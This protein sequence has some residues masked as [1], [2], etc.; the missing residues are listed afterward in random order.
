METKALMWAWMAFDRDK[1]L[2]LFE[3]A[4]AAIDEMRTR[5]A[6]DR[7]D[8]DVVEEARRLGIFL[9]VVDV[10]VRVVSALTAPA[11]STAQP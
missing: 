6:K 4:S 9:C 8:A 10:T 7:S 3:T 11:A 5:I 2:D 1:K